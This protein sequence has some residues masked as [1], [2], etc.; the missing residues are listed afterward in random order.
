MKLVWSSLSLIEK[1]CLEMEAMSQRAAGIS[2]KE[3]RPKKV[4]APFLLME[5]WSLMNEE[6]KSFFK[7]AAQNISDKSKKKLPKWG[8]ESTIA[9]GTPVVISA[10]NGNFAVEVED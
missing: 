5:I 8:S 7:N 3:H 9:F 6:T 10:I 2:I 1:Q 4:N